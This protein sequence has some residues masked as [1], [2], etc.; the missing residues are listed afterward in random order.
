[1]DQEKVGAFMQTLR[2]EKGLTQK[3]LAEKLCV[4]DKTIS[5]WEN[6][7]SLPDT[8]FLPDLCRELD[9][10]VNEL[11]SCERLSPDEYSKKSEVTIMDLM[12]ENQE[13]KKG[14]KVQLAL[15][16]VF[17]I[18]TLVLFGLSVGFSL[19]WLFDFPTILIITFAALAAVLISGKRKMKDIVSLLR[20]VIIPIGVL[21][22]LFSGISMLRSLDTPASIGPKIAAA[23][24]SLMYA[25][26][27]Y[28]ILTVM[29]RE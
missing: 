7:N 17:L 25:V 21:V 23:F 9:I 11:I 14:N 5:K 27:I 2:K 28:L 18:L 24:I 12:K 10:S 1:M 8:S 20:K 6:G 19:S 4:S 15:G 22:A 13:N 29:D 26:I 3:E 16:I